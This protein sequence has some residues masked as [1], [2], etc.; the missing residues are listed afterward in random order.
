[1]HPETCAVN[2][3]YTG[4]NGELLQSHAYSRSIVTAYMTEKKALHLS[5][6]VQM[7]KTKQDC[8]DSGLSGYDTVSLGE[9]LPTF[10]RHRVPSKCQEPLIQ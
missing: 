8:N 1:M 10:R 2:D 7:Y 5:Q 4:A 9:N 3:T 6:N